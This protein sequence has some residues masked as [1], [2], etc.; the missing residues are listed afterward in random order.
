MDTSSYRNTPFIV[1][2]FYSYAK[3]SRLSGTLETAIQVRSTVVAFDRNSFALLGSTNVKD[4][5]TWTMDIFPCAM[6][7]ILVIVKDDTGQYNCD[8][9]DRVTQEVE[10]ISPEDFELYPNDVVHKDVTSTTFSES[11]LKCNGSIVLE[12]ELG[13]ESITVEDD[14]IA[15]VFDDEDNEMS[16]SGLY[17]AETDNGKITI[18][19]S[20]ISP[21]L[22]VGK[23]ATSV[24]DI[25]NDNSC[26]LH[27]Q[28]EKDFITTD[29]KLCYYPNF[30]KYYPVRTLGKNN[31]YKNMYLVLSQYTQQ[32][33]IPI[34]I[35]F[36]F[37]I[38]FNINRHSPITYTT[39]HTI[40]SI[41]TYPP[42]QSKLTGFTIG[43]DTVPKYRC[44]VGGS[45]QQQFNAPIKIG[46][47]EHV[48]ICCSTTEW[49]LF[50]D[51]VS[52]GSFTHPAPL[53]TYQLLPHVPSLF[54]I[55]IYGT[56]AVM[57]SLLSDVRVFNKYLTPSEA[58][59]VTAT[60]E[61]NVV[62]KSISKLS[63]LTASKSKIGAIGF[64]NINLAVDLSTNKLSSYDKS[65]YSVINMFG[66][67]LYENGIYLNGSSILHKVIPSTAINTNSSLTNQ[68]DL[69]F[70]IRFKNI[71]MLFTGIRC[72]YK[73]GDSVNGIAVYTNGYTVAICGRSSG[74]LTTLSVPGYLS[75]GI[76]YVIV[77]DS[78]GLS[79][80]SSRFELLQRTPGQIVAG[81]SSTDQESI[82]NSAGNSPISGLT[83]P[84]EYFRGLIEEITFIEKPT[85]SFSSVDYKKIAVQIG[86]TTVQCP[87]EVF[88]IDP[89]YNISKIRAFIPEISNSHN[90][91]LRV[92]ANS[93]KQDNSNVSNQ[94]SVI[95]PSASSDW[96]S[97]L[98][99]ADS[100]ELGTHNI[101]KHEGVVYIGGSEI[102]YLSYNFPLYMYEL[103]GLLKNTVTRLNVPGYG[104]VRSNVYHI[105]DR[106]NFGNSYSEIVLNSTM[107]DFR[108]GIITKVFP[109]NVTDT[110]AS[111][112]AATSGYIAYLD[113][114]DGV[115]KIY[116]HNGLVTTLTGA[117][118]PVQGTVIQFFFTNDTLDF[119]INNTW[120]PPSR[121]VSISFDPFVSMFIELSDEGASATFNICE[122][123]F[124]FSKPVG[125]Y[126]LRDNLFHSNFSVEH[127]SFLIVAAACN[128]S[129]DT[130]LADLSP[131]GQRTTI[132]G[133][134]VVS[135]I[136]DSLFPNG[137]VSHPGSP[138]I[139][140]LS[141]SVFHP[142]LGD[143][144]LDFYAVRETL[145]PYEYVMG[146][147]NSF[148]SGFFIS[149][150]DNKFSVSFLG[151]QDINGEMFTKSGVRTIN[152]FKKHHYCL[153]IDSGIL[154]LFVD[155]I[156][157]LK[158]DIQ[159][160]VYGVD[161]VFSIGNAGNTDASKIFAGVIFCVRIFKGKA[162]W[163][164]NFIVP[165]RE[166]FIGNNYPWLS[167]SNNYNYPS[168]PSRRCLSYTLPTTAL[169]L[170]GHSSSNNNGKKY[171]EFTLYN[172][173]N[174]NILCGFS[175]NPLA[176][177]MSANGLAIIQTHCALN[178]AIIYYSYP[179]SVIDET[180]IGVAIDFTTGKFYIAFNGVW[181]GGVTWKLPVLEDAVGTFSPTNLSMPLYPIVT[182][183][184]TS[185]IRTREEEFLF[186]CPTGFDPWDESVSSITVNNP[187][188]YLK[189]NSDDSYLSR[190][191]PANYGGNYPAHLLH[192][193]GLY[194]NNPS[195]YFFVNLF[196]Y[197]KFSLD[198]LTPKIDNRMVF[199]NSSSPTVYQDGIRDF[200]L[201][202]TNSEAAFENNNFN[203]VDDL[204]IL[205]TFTAAVF[206]SHSSR[207]QIF[208]YEENP[209]PFRYRV[210]RVLNNHGGTG[211]RATYMEFQRS[212]ESTE[213]KSIVA[214]VNTNLLDMDLQNFPLMVEFKENAGVTDFDSSFIFDRIG[215]NFLKLFAYY[216][217]TES[218]PIE[219][220]KWDAAERYAKIY[221][222]VPKILGCNYVNYQKQF[223]AIDFSDEGKLVVVGK[224]ISQQ[225]IKGNTYS[226]AIKDDSFSVNGHNAFKYTG[227]LQYNGSYVEFKNPPI[228][229]LQDTLFMQTYLKIQNYGNDRSVLEAKQLGNTISSIIVKS[230]N[231]V[232]VRIQNMNYDTG[233]YLQAGV[234][235][236]IA[237][238]IDSYLMFLYLNGESVYVIEHT[239]YYL[240]YYTTLYSIYLV[241]NPVGGQSYCLPSMFLGKEPED[242]F[243]VP[244][245]HVNENSI[246]T[247]LVFDF[248]MDYSDN[249][250]I[251][252]PGSDA[253]TSVWDKFYTV[254][255]HMDRIESGYVLDSTSNAYHG[256]VGAGA[257]I[258]NG[259]LYS[260]GTGTAVT[261][262][263]GIPN[264]SRTHSISMNFKLDGPFVNSKYIVYSN[265]VTFINELNGTDPGISLR[266]MPSQEAYRISVDMDD[267]HHIIFSQFSYYTWEYLVNGV[268]ST[269]GQLYPWKRDITNDYKIGGTALE[270][271]KGYFGEFRVS[272]VYRSYTWK[273]V[274]ELS[275]ADKLCK[276]SDIILGKYVKNALP[277]WEDSSI[278]EFFVNTSGLTETLYNFPLDLYFNNSSG[279]TNEDFTGFFSNLS[280]KAEVNNSIKSYKFGANKNLNGFFLNNTP[281]GTEK[282]I[283]YGT[284]LKFT[285]GLFNANNVFSVNHFENFHLQHSIS[286]RFKFLGKLGYS[287]YG[288]IGR[289]SS[290]SNEFL[291]TMA[292]STNNYMNFYLFG[293]N[294]YGLSS[295]SL[296]TVPV[297]NGQYH[298]ITM[299]R[300][301]NP[302]TKQYRQKI[303]LDGNIIID[304]DSG[305][306]N[307]NSS[308]DPIYIGTAN[309]QSVATFNGY[310]DDVIISNQEF[311]DEEARFYAHRTYRKDES[312]HKTVLAKQDYSIPVLKG[313][314][315]SSLSVDATYATGDI[316][317]CV[318][319]DLLTYYAYKDNTWRS[320]ATKNPDVHGT[321]GNTNWHYK[322]AVGDFIECIDNDEAICISVANSVVE[323]R[324]SASDIGN[325]NFGTS[326]YNAL[327]GVCE[328]ALTISYS[329]VGEYQDTPEINKIYFNNKK[330]Q[331]LKP[332]E[333]EEYNESLVSSSIHWE[334]DMGTD[335]IDITNKINVYCKLSNAT[336]WSQCTQASELPVITA[337]MNTVGKQLHIKVEVAMDA[338][339]QSEDIIVVTKL[340]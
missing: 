178:S 255:Y 37:S 229:T 160:G 99:L 179:T 53:N 129:G 150:I 284:G 234:V 219:V 128:T 193:S 76:E 34:Y 39:T 113:Y 183:F 159:T 248:S 59:L 200:I 208:T 270:C 18:D 49:E 102:E 173:K 11:V 296:V 151:S 155:G 338:G 97:F 43:S 138:Y 154:Y 312:L 317:A 239:T 33:E 214:E 79:L 67:I 293:L 15:H 61:T 125:S 3:A 339:I 10:V 297:L 84:S 170:H 232:R 171:I 107:T 334:Y 45:N 166:D 146:T 70:V 252:T 267:W 161:S 1:E 216:D 233:I 6:K 247:R 54:S 280:Y 311:T 74:V 246:N 329:G 323:N 328:V 304:E 294:T 288:L 162:R 14:T 181:V 81:A 63:K 250:N 51:G 25:F 291:V 276:Y 184:D 236:H 256:L 165:N 105:P 115:W 62:S 93:L 58:A 101:L 121:T 322:N 152:D 245:G 176:Q 206:T 89:V 27:A 68:G 100:D 2:K 169:Y 204:T 180:T 262:P 69:Y 83:N 85:I 274:E 24:T 132:Q 104:N 95:P 307:P 285:E 298:A 186:P 191:T 36:P 259:Y 257:S 309:Y 52:K 261:L 244:T 124:I 336:T 272:N 147:V 201:Y 230:T 290:T 310:I 209:T 243:G 316:F 122:S 106:N 278:S 300:T 145:T 333:L 103:S 77:Y 292:T 295:T 92:Y 126:S 192:R 337:G 326:L 335:L 220:I 116:R 324:V 319:F 302:L 22:S 189:R 301:L 55:G 72:L 87:V 286:L 205:G 137:F 5:G 109:N 75:N 9:Y 7:N 114:K 268:K 217:K 281:F 148:G 225:F 249:S 130:I 66:N 141:S 41:Y 38:S 215:N 211:L 110:T 260:D 158:T 203:N 187:F 175:N 40:I 136:Q 195:L 8:N 163:T 20:Y 13:V 199:V 60:D 90:L 265:T 143:Y 17:E 26:I 331:V 222:K 42:L 202:G 196:T 198:L 120:V 273:R 237:V 315:L 47:I 174:T 313:S 332:I 314:A 287:I 240:W 96:N 182:S 271:I 283:S 23:M 50:I 188:D 264:D 238:F 140:F 144:S 242:V 108:V 289:G 73:S 197:A 224:Y 4:D 318:S 305:T 112:V 78:N 277:G 172:L 263:V 212:T 123:D 275:T 19:G 269:T 139:S 135:T 227:L 16:L 32:F 253:A 325:W 31:K 258:V 127:T 168:G 71:N 29:N 213:N 167:S 266:F 157:D 142:E 48:T 82:G 134:Q 98:T 156:L 210:V 86:E 306:T 149:F 21:H 133:S 80:Y 94:L 30:S 226:V 35:T 117:P 177:D 118:N 207:V 251:G 190:C 221:V 254:V 279:L 12:N 56:T 185:R 320:I 46:G 44:T 218:I 231:E 330:I 111:G 303:Y 88:N 91:Y 241:L 340:M 299:V 28:F 64:N 119:G 194:V 327:T 65:N 223:V 228:S 321:V 235:Y 131:G 153:T 282:G 57:P 308:N 164:D